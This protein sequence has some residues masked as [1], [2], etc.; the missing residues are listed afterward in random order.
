MKQETEEVKG[1]FK[2]MMSMM[3]GV[4]SEVASMKGEL[5]DMRQE[6]ADVKAKSEEA[7]TQSKEALKTA[8]DAKSSVETLVKTVN[9]LKNATM[10]KAEAQA[11]IKDELCKHSPAAKP[12]QASAVSQNRIDWPRNM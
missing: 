9:E 3:K 2:Q 6:F 11:M 10:S 5:G 1:M 7:K 4:K 12:S 8:C